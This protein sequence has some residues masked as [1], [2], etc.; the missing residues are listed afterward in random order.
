MKLLLASG[1][2]Y[3]KSLLER[4]HL[5]FDQSSPDIDE[6]PLHNESPHQLVIR[7]ARQ[8]AQT[9]A[10]QHPNTLIIASDQAA[11]LNGTILGK[12]NTEANAI[13]Q[14]TLCSG[15]K[16]T[17]HTSLCLLNTRTNHFQIEDIEFN[18]WFR[19]LNQQQITH[20]IKEER[21][22]DCAGSFKCEGL[23]IALF[24]RMS[25][26]DPNSLIGLPLISLVSMLNN[27]GVNVLG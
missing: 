20:Y 15:Q 14:L 27:E 5:T 9:L 18:V 1:S 6:S 8:K 13:E 21:P 17:F 7:L 16:V 4:L 10:P 22:L 24:E 11:D 23:G 19:T 2:P 3:R 12:P 26:D 25:G